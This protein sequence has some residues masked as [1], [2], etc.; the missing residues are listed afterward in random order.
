MFRSQSSETSLLAKNNTY[1][2][3]LTQA[4]PM[5]VKLMVRIMMMAVMMM[6]VVMVKKMA[7]VMVMVIVMKIVFIIYDQSCI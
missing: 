4:F 1:R 6:V 3:L 2:T 7:V 5:V